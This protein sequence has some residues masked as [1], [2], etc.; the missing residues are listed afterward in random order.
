MGLINSPVKTIEII[1][2][3]S[4][5]L[6][7]SSWTALWI[8][9]KVTTPRALSA[10]WFQSNKRLRK[11]NTNLTCCAWS[12]AEKSEL[13]TQSHPVPSVLEIKHY[14]CPRA[15]LR[16]CPSIALRLTFWHWVARACFLSALPG[17]AQGGYR[18]GDPQ[19]GR[20]KSQI[21]CSLTSPCCT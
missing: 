14:H 20:Y 7:S 5:G 6:T 9:M 10:L 19:L 4:A 3:T 15:G 8:Q 21:I 11:F 2:L 12:A 18:N 17:V 1:S 13:N 16:V